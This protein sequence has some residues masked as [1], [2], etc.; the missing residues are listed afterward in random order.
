MAFTLRTDAILENG[1]FDPR[2]TC[3]IDNSSP[4]LRWEDPP[5]N[6]QGFALIVEDLSTPQ[7]FVHWVVY[8]IPVN[9]HHLPAG[10][11]AQ[12]TLPNGIKQGI[13]GWGKLGYGGPCPPQPSE[14]HLY[15]FRLYALERLNPIHPK[16]RREELL[17]AI[18]PDLLAATELRAKYQRMLKVAS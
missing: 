5:K 15:L 12:E 14:A 2:Y 11:P 3:D 16:P 1:Y 18:A 17:Q 9:V 4:E 13:N 10:I 7:R 8:Q 6:T